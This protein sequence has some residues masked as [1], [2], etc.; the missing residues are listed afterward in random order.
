MLLQRTQ[1]ERTSLF[2]LLKHNVL[3]FNVVIITICEDI[4]MWEE[5]HF[6][7]DDV[8]EKKNLHFSYTRKRFLRRKKTF[9]FVFYFYGTTQMTPVILFF[10][11]TTFFR[12]RPS[13]S[14]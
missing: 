4:I 9:W 5:R 14:I 12:R 6:V 11:P 13:F 10:V 8:I 3:S 2:A 1:R 7:Y